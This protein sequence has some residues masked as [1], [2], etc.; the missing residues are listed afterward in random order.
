MTHLETFVK[1]LEEQNSSGFFDLRKRY[2]VRSVKP[3]HP[4]DNQ[5]TV[6]VDIPDFKVE[7]VFWDGKYKGIVLLP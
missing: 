4:S 6:V 5:N 7:F 3:G 1:M 2:S